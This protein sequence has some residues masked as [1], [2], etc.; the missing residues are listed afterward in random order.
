MPE[1]VGPVPERIAPLAS[2]SEVRRSFLTKCWNRLHASVTPKRLGLLFVAGPLTLWAWLTVTKDVVSIAVFSSGKGLED[3]GLTGLFLTNRVVD[4]IA[5]LE[6][7]SLTTNEHNFQQATAEDIPE[8]E[9]PETKISL[10]SIVQ[11]LRTVI[12]QRFVRAITVDGDAI[13][14]GTTI[15]IVARI[16]DPAQG[17]STVIGPVSCSVTNSAGCTDDIAEGIVKE[18]DPVIIAIYWNSIDANPNR[19]LEF[20]KGKMESKT[21]F[22]DDLELFLGTVTMDQGRLSV[23]EQTFRNVLNRSPQNVNA[24]LL[25]GRYY[26]QIEDF[27]TASQ[28]YDAARRL[29]SR[30]PEALNNSAY[31]ILDNGNLRGA[32]D[33]FEEALRFHPRYTWAYRGRANVLDQLGAENKAMSV[34]QLGISSSPNE[35]DRSSANEALARYLTDKN[36]PQRALA[37]AHEAIKLN[38]ADPYGFIALGRALLLTRR[39][40]EA[41]QAYESALDLSPNKA[42]VYLEWG[43]AFE[44]QQEY[45]KALEV[46]ALANAADPWSPLPLAEAGRLLIKIRRLRE[47]EDRF[48]RA[49]DVAPFRFAV[50]Y[51]WGMAYQEAGDPVNALNRFRQA[52]K[53]KDVYPIRTKIAESEYAAHQYSAGDIDYERAILQNPYPSGELENWG[54]SLVDQGRVRRAQEVLRRAVAADYGNTSAHLRLATLL[55]RTGATAESETEFRRAIEVAAYPSGVLK[56]QASVEGSMGQTRS[57][58]EHLKQAIALDPENSDARVTLARQLFQLGWNQIGE[59]ELS[60]AAETS[61]TPASVHVEWGEM[62]YAKRAFSDAERHFARAVELTPT[63]IEAW[64]GM[65]RSRREQRR[66]QDAADAVSALMRLNLADPRVYSTAASYFRS[67]AK[68]DDALQTYERAALRFPWTSEPLI[69]RGELLLRLNRAAEAWVNFE[70]ASLKEPGNPGLLVRCADAFA[71]Q[72]E[73]AAAIQFYDRALR[74][75]SNYVDGS[76]GKAKVTARLGTTSPAIELCERA[77]GIDINVVDCYMTEASILL[78]SSKYPEALHTYDKAL[79]LEPTRVAL[80]TGKERVYLSMPGAENN[81][82][83]RTLWEAQRHGLRSP[84]LH[85]L[86]GASYCRAGMFAMADQHF[87][88]AINDAPTDSVILGDFAECLASQENWTAVSQRYREALALSADYLPLYGIVDYPRGLS[89]EPTIKGLADE[90]P[91]LAQDVQSEWEK[92]IGRFKALQRQYSQ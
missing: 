17:V 4:H 60:I 75:D 77:S 30:Q 63:R 79:A 15:R 10:K 67:V 62:L 49:L 11:F 87:Q 50:L 35:Q 23:A 84:E 28:Y 2:N 80:Y 64:D 73:N 85:Q 36:N 26:E 32:S 65:I 51:R 18:V 5:I 29:D 54:R 45:E 22:Q 31:R 90:K 69:A 89:L 81:S 66:Y 14:D 74:I 3:E 37:M 82:A 83:L 47:A 7:A 92:R 61:L 68:Y 88:Q 20:V 39:E 53:E 70:Q 24:L 44:D 41:R 91:H 6:T 48:R 40:K 27:G 58:I 1:I 52:Q 55:K 46:Y 8:V 25:L 43:R 78:T 59:S 56:E 71:S 38:A 19:S 12:P 34:L 76:L 42:S 33:M 72:V 16:H 57:A 9:L 86:L 21:R 13:L